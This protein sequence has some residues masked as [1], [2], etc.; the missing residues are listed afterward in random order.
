MS[1]VVASQPYCLENSLNLTRPGSEAFYQIDGHDAP[2]V[3]DKHQ[4]KRLYRLQRVPYVKTTLHLE[5]SAEPLNESTSFSRKKVYH[6]P[7]DMSDA[8]MARFSFGKSRPDPQRMVPSQM[9]SARNHPAAN[10]SLRDD[11]DQRSVARY[12]DRAVSDQVVRTRI[13]PGGGINANELGEKTKA[14]LRN[15]DRLPTQMPFR[16]QPRSTVDDLARHYMY[17]S[18]QQAAFDEVAWGKKKHSIDFF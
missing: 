15:G 16:K 18:T 11:D 6:Q 1:Q 10:M 8:S 5:P 9:T 3:V 7:M 2:T 13:G 12:T 4:A 14:Y 17:T